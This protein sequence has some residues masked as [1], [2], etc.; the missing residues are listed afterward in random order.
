MAPRH[1]NPNRKERTAVAP[2]NFIPP[3]D[4]PLL[5]ADRSAGGEWVEDQ[6]IYKRGRH[7]G[8]LDVT[9]ETRAP[10]YVRGPLETDD[11]DRMEQQES[12][13]ND[14]T[15][16]LRK[17]RNRPDFFHQGNPNRPVLPGS[18][19][20]GMIRSIV[21]ILGYGKLSPVTDQP[22]VY[23]SIDTSAHGEFYR[24]R[25]MQE[26]PNQK[27]YFTPRFKAGY[28]R[29]QKGDWYIQPAQEMGGATYARIPIE[30]IPRNLKRWYNCRNANEIYIQ[31]GPYQFQKVRG[32]FLHIKY[33][34]VLRAAEQEGPGLTK[35]ALIRSGQ[36]FSKK[37]E[38]IVFPGDKDENHW[39]RV[40][41][42]SQEGEADLVTAYKD[43]ITPEQSDLL[44]PKGVLQEQQPVF[45]LVENGRLVFFG[46]TQLFRLPYPHSPRLLLGAGHQENDKRLDM[47]EALFGRVKGK[48]SGQAGRV[49]VTDGRLEKGQDSPWLEE[50]P[51]VIPQ[52][53][54]GPKP[55]TF[56]HYLAQPQP[57]VEQGKALLSYN[58][59]PKETTLRGHKMYWHKGK[60]ERRDIAEKKPVDEGKDSQHTMMRPV[61]PGM[62]FHFRVYFE[63]LRPQELGL[64]WWAVALPA[65][66]DY[67]HK[68]GMGKPLGLGAVKLEP[69]LT[70]LDPQGRYEKLLVEQEGET[71][72][73]QGTKPV[74]QTAKDLQDALGDFETLMLTATRKSE[75]NAQAFGRLER[76]QMLLKML[77]WPGP[78]PEQTRYMEI[79]RADPTAKRGKRNEYKERPVLSDPLEVG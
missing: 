76:V 5:F 77:A 61:R 49:F 12:D 45:Y 70:L 40:P 43:Q 46:H 72:W 79:E 54:S 30:S 52:I 7:T 2:Y 1:K 57:D 23:R 32:G 53:L 68:L 24:R 78:N 44:G 55:T 14:R 66:G 75:P 37:S 17:L 35:A 6:D 27:N 13:P 67:C 51:V 3:A 38:A 73:A 29:Q 71:D 36:M 18:S 9:L 74:E 47:A 64:L 62:H 34:K 26:D 48:E 63:N 11:Y 41:D 50:Q 58:H 69:K 65:E 39:L 4:P 22:L 42:G 28:M 33:A 25:M 31:P 60:V 56:Q 15:P 8:W 21:E 19:L 16:H 10:L 20:R 59:S